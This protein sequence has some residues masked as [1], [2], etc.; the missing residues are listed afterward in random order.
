M[1]TRRTTMIGLG[2]L[3]L[4]ATVLGSSALGVSAGVSSDF[5]VIVYA[6]L[7]LTPGR[8]DAGYVE[9]DD[10]GQ[11]VAINLEGNDGASG[12]NQHARTRLED[13]VRLTNNGDVPVQE[14][15]FEFDVEDEGLKSGDP[16]PEE[17]EEALQIVS[18]SGEIEASGDVD[19]FSISEAE[20]LEDGEL[21]PGESISFGVQLNL[22]PDMGS[23]SIGSLPDSDR[24][25]VNLKIQA[26]LP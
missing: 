7:T 9:V 25:S 20:E 18:A 21:A 12:I 13:L 6:N 11:V 22:Q 26:V 4:G 15:Y 19:F 10:D 2:Q 16:T 1:P 23:G 14:L 17:I 8:D 5:R 3:V 24:F